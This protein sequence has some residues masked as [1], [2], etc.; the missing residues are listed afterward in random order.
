MQS[1]GHFPPEMG[2]PRAWKGLDL[3]E[4][5]FYF[6]VILD[7][8]DPVNA[9]QRLLDHL[10]LIKG[11]DFTSQDDVPTGAL[12]VNAS[13]ASVGIR[14]DSQT[15]SAEQWAGR[16]E[17]PL[18]RRC[19]EETKIEWGQDAPGLDASL[20][21]PPKTGYELEIEFDFQQM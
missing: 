16:H 8:I 18:T 9:P 10:L 5:L 1:G 15:N 6:Q 11:I 13:A 17:E 3:P 4:C 19:L 21:F 2:D 20:V 12:K 7:R 14:L